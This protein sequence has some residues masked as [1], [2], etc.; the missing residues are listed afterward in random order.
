MSRLIVVFIISLMVLRALF[1]FNSVKY[2]PGSKLRISGVVHEVRKISDSYLFTI[3]DFQLSTDSDIKI[4]VGNKVM[5][6]GVVKERNWYSKEMPVQL[7]HV[8]IGRSNEE[9]S[10]LSKFRNW[11]NR[12]FRELLPTQ[13]ASLV[14]GALLGERNISWD[15]REKTR[16]V[17]LSH[18][19]VAS[20]TNVAILG[21]FVVSTLAF[22]IGRRKALIVAAGLIWIFAAM[23]EFEPP[24]VRASLMA[25]LS[26]LAVAFGRPT[27]A[28]RLLA[29]SVAFMVFADPFLLFSLSFQ[30][31][32]AATMGVIWSQKVHWGKLN[33]ARETV[34]AQVATAP[35]LISRLGI[36][37]ISW[38]GPISNLIVLWTVPVIMIL[39][40]LV[41]STS[42]IEFAVGEIGISRSA[43]VLLY[44]PTHFF[45]VVVENL[46]GICCG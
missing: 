33:F 37:A 31:S 29:V 38:I 26:Y 12:V 23:V 24:I 4:Q 39:G 8:D 41:L 9:I 7:I 6:T 43:A 14:S 21:G 1:V 19:V 45:V 36:G 27:N 2:L 40:V 13:E 16:E 22:L 20:G 42:A 25:T 5:A 3:G 28:L 10:L 11:A 32:V 30:L 18:V 17:G 15:F 44:V 34:M 35:V 46:W